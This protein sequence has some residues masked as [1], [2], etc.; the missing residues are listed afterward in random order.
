MGESQKLGNASLDLDR[1]VVERAR[2][3]GAGLEFLIS[4]VWP[5]AYRLSYML[6]R[7]GGLAEDAAQDAC[8]SIARSLPRLKESGA[9]YAWSYK[10]ITRSAIT[11]GRRRPKVQSLDSVARGVV[12]VDRSDALDLD[13]ALATLPLAQRIAI[14]LHYYSGLSSREISAACGMPSSTVRFHLMLA[15]R[16]L[17]K[18]FTTEEA[19]SARTLTDVR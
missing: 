16:A 1:E 10:I 18:Y 15:R 9:F 14:V 3:G 12:H 5:E 7:D 8:V 13:L 6:L 11:I 2:S 4:E 17:R 19:L